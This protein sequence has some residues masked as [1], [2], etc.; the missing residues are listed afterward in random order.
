M[1]KTFKNLDEQI[2][3]LESKGLEITDYEKTKEILFNTVPQVP[4][5]NNGLPK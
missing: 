4:K 1:Q 3:I 5:I 2:E